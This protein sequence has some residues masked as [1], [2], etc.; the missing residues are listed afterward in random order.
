MKRNILLTFAHIFLAIIVGLVYFGNPLNK[1][2]P[3]QFTALL[4]IITGGVI[5]ILELILHLHKRKIKRI[6]IY[7]LVALALLIVYFIL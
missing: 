7:L 4:S 1:I 3:P 5:L 6:L 2:Y